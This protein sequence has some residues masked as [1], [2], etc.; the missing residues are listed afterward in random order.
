MRAVLQKKVEKRIPA[1]SSVERNLETGVQFGKYQESSTTFS[2]S[3]LGLMKA[4][5][6]S[7]SKHNSLLMKS[8]RL[9]S[10]KSLNDAFKNLTEDAKNEI[11]R[12]I[13]VK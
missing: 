7:I 13:G 2:V 4:N 8:K 6:F 12:M 11:S 1:V 10:L 9:N 5:D 3:N